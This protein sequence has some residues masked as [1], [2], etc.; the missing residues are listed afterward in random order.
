MA[1]F[2]TPVYRNDRD[3]TVNVF[4]ARR[5]CCV[6]ALLAPAQPAPLLAPPRLPRQPAAPAPLRAAPTIRVRGGDVIKI[7]LRNNLTRP[8][9]PAGTVVPLNGFAHSADT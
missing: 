2:T 8:A 5:R 9:E 6:G 3:G 1:D 7:D 4:G